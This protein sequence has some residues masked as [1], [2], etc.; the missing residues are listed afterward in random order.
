MRVL[1]LLAAWQCEGCLESTQKRGGGSER[2]NEGG[3]KMGSSWECMP[4][5]RASY[6]NR[7]QF[8]LFY[9]TDALPRLWWEHVSREW[10]GFLVMFDFLLFLKLHVLL[11]SYLLFISIFFIAVSTMCS[12]ISNMGGPTEENSWGWWWSD[13]MMIVLMMLKETLDFSCFLLQD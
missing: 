3:G 7:C 11:Y 2:E 5:M 6:C 9:R 12:C 8:K 4:C 13:E 1:L 10:S